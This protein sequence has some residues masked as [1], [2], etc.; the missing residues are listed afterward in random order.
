MRLA[1]PRR[2][3]EKSKLAAG[4]RGGGHLGTAAHLCTPTCLHA[5]AACARRSGSPNPARPRS[6]GSACAPAPERPRPPTLGSYSWATVRRCRRGVTGVT[7]ETLSGGTRASSATVL[8]GKPSLGPVGWQ[9]GHVTAKTRGPPLRCA[10]TR[11][12]AVQAQGGRRGR[13]RGHRVLLASTRGEAEGVTAPSRERGWRRRTP[14]P[15]SHK[16]ARRGPAAPAGP[17][18]S[19]V[20]HSRPARAGS[21]A[22]AALAGR[23]GTETSTR[24][25]P[26]PGPRAPRPH[27][28]PRARDPAPRAYLGPGPRRAPAALAEPDP[29]TRAAGGSCSALLGSAPPAPRRPRLAE[30]LLRAGLGVRG[31]ELGVRGSGSGR[32][33]QEQPGGGGGGAAA[34]HPPPGPLRH[35]GAP[36]AGSP[37]PCTD[38]GPK[39]P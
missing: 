38:W 16:R 3:P 23:A 14:L 4:P 28:A 13:G 21:S 36:R 30:R 29:A 12:A 22:P 15:A 2:L 10:R 34:S 11:P 33:R 26:G 8:M 19:S 7:V 6:P 18:Q 31:A 32:P 5:T 35:R 27:P 24:A 9:S 25:A 37:R 20:P 17:A 1:A 39:S